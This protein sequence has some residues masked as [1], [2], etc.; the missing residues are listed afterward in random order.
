MLNS[1]FNASDLVFSPPVMFGNLTVVPILNKKAT[2]QDYLCLDEAM[3]LGVAQVTE[4]SVNGSVPELYFLNNGDKP[5]LLLDGEEL[6]GAKQN[7]VLNLTIM[8]PAYSKVIIPV[9]CVEQGRWSWRSSQF[10]AANRTLFAEARVAKMSQV[11]RSMSNSTNYRS[12][13]HEIWNS[14]AAKSERFSVDSSTSAAS[15]IYENRAADLDKFVE[16]FKT[17]DGQVGAAFIVKGKLAGTEL[18][19]DTKALSQLLPKLI[20]SY[21]LDSLDKSISKKSEPIDENALKEF[22]ELILNTPGL[23]KK[24]IGLGEDIRIESKKIL[25]AALVSEKGLIHLSAFAR[26]YGSTRH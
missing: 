1:Y 26:G 6:V 21:G 13:Q 14:I 11:T 7:R 12:D 20:R 10:K 5:I 25:A 8:V 17:T 3:N 9:S 23:S 19:G 15:D 24:A 18:F 4:T 2:N 22:Y 16:Q